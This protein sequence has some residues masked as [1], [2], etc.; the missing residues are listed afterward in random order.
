MLTSV[1]HT[2]YVKELGTLTKCI[3]QLLPINCLMLKC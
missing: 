2:E 3:L 1:P